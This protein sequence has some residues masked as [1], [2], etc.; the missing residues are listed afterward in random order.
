MNSRRPDIDAAKGLGMCLVI[1]GHAQPPATLATLIYGMHM[2]LFFLLSGMLWRGHV[3]LRHSTRALWQPFVLASLFSWLLWLLKQRLHGTGDVPWWG[4]LAVTAYGGNLNGWLVHNTPLWFLPA[5]LSL[6]GALWLLTRVLDAS[7][8]LA[9]LAATGLVVVVFA[10]SLPG[11]DWPMSLAQGLVGG[12]FF[13]MGHASARPR[14]A[15]LAT[16]G[17]GAAAVL[18]A[19]G[20][21]LLNGR[22]DLYSLQL[23]QPVLY[24]SAGFFGAWGLA[25]LCRAPALQMPWLCLIGR[26]SLLILALHMPLLWLLR[27]GLRA[28][29]W[30]EAW[31]L[32]SLSC[33][34]AMAAL[35]LWR[36]RSHP[37]TQAA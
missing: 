8:A 24:L 7:R 32:L 22:V 10:N 20:L 29:K 9:V 28:A 25:A 4:P 17:R 26:H 13:A 5:M 14:W 37:P 1:A 21:S 36:D 34:T 31:W 15:A 35:S 3:Q 33:L 16:P 6:L 2:P 23:G 27:A 11:H 18:L 30:P 19:A 12:L